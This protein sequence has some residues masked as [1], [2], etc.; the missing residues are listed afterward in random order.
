MLVAPPVVGEEEEDVR[1]LLGVSH[2]TELGEKNEEEEA[3]LHCGTGWT[4]PN[5]PKLA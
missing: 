3:A 5:A 2:G 4:I 1:F